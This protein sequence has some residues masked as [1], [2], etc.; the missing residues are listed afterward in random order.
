M[1]SC[2][3]W[4]PKG[5]S[6]TAKSADPAKDATPALPRTVRA[7]LAALRAIKIIILAVWIQCLS[8]KSNVHGGQF[9]FSILP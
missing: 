5:V 2:Q 6:G 9:D 3:L 1:L 7:C 8:R 4:W